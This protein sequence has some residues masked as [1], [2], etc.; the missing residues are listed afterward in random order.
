MMK[1][2]VAMEMAMDV[3]VSLTMRIAIAMKT[4]MILRTEVYC[5]LWSYKLEYKFVK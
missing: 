5:N 3:A 1:S 4:V 2:T